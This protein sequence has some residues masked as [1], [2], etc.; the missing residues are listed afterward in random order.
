MELII[1]AEV[2]RQN[3]KRFFENVRDI[4]M[5]VAAYAL[6]PLV[7]ATLLVV[8]LLEVTAY[9]YLGTNPATLSLGYNSSSNESNTLARR[10]RKNSRAAR[11]RRPVALALLFC[12]DA[13]GQLPLTVRPSCYV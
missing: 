13:A 3:L 5:L 10:F 9:S 12:V 1:E 6:G 7:S 4:V 8:S 2:A 11:H